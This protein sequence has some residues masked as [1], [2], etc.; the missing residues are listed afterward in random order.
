MICWGWFCS[1]SFTFITFPNP[2]SNPWAPVFKEELIE[3]FLLPFLTMF[4]IFDVFW[5]L[6]PWAKMQPFSRHDIKRETSVNHNLSMNI[7]LKR[8]FFPLK[9]QYLE[10]LKISVFDN[11]KRSLSTTPYDTFWGSFLLQYHQF[12]IGAHPF[13]CFSLT[14]RSIIL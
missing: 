8:G 11:L 12:K 1:W 5:L 13:W 2:L 6:S 4:Y 9:D 10:V 7:L 3:F 14:V